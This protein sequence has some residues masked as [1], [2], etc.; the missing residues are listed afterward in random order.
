MEKEDT[1]Y[2]WVPGPTPH[3]PYTLSSAQ[4]RTMKVWL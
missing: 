4:I 1:V 2:K 3:L